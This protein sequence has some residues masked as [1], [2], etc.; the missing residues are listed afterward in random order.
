[1]SRR[2]VLAREPDWLKRRRTPNV[3]LRSIASTMKVKNSKALVAFGAVML[4]GAR[5]AQASALKTATTLSSEQSNVTAT[6]LAVNR[7]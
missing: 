5:G 4:L 6:A 7:P 1:M 3:T 2:L